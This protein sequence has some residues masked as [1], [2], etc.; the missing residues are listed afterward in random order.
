M[1]SF[2]V[3]IPKKGA[4]VT[5][6]FKFVRKCHSAIAEVALRLEIKKIELHILRCG[7]TS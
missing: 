2:T 5:L 6:R 3:K 1:Y 7:F 4:E